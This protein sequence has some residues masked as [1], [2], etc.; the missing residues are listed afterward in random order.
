M[1]YEGAQIEAS[2][3]KTATGNGATQGA[4][5][6]SKLSVFVDCTAVSGT[7]PTLDL[8]VQWSHDGTNFADAEPVDS[9]VQITVAKK[10]VKVFDWKAPLYRLAWTIAGTTPSFT[11]SAR[12][13]VV[14]G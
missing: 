11:F 1:A 6:G 8:K 14:A 4:P 10:V 3:A 13:Y 12:S 7:T 5:V 9:F 2:S